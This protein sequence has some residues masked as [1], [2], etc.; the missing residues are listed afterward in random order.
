[1]LFTFWHHETK[2]TPKSINGAWTSQGFKRDALRW[3]L[4]LSL[5]SQRGIIRLQQRHGDTG[6]V[7]ERCRSGSP[8]ATSHDDDRHFCCCCWRISTVVSIN[9]SFLF[10]SPQ[11]S[12]K[13]EHDRTVL[14]IYLFF[15]FIDFNPEVWMLVRYQ[16]RH[17]FTLFLFCFVLNLSWVTIKDLNSNYLLSHFTMDAK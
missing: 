5:G 1:M 9:C 8:L 14:F 4:L 6:R 15:F 12:S 10:S 17:S 13:I 3:K 2:T 16:N 11:I 7:P